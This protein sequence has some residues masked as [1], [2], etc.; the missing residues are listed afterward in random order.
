MA[1]AGYNKLLQKLQERTAEAVELRREL[2]ARDAE[3]ATLQAVAHTPEVAGEGRASR[4]RWAELEKDAVI[5]LSGV[6]IS[7]LISVVLQMFGVDDPVI[8][9]LSLTA[10]ALWL[11][12]LFVHFSVRYLQGWPHRLAAMVIPSVLVTIAFVQIDHWFM[13][14]RQERGHMPS[15]RDFIAAFKS[16]FPWLAQPPPPSVLTALSDSQFNEIRQIDALIG[17]KDEMELRNTFDFPNMLKF[18]LLLIRRSADTDSV[19]PSESKEMDAYWAGG[20]GIVDS[21]YLRISRHGDGPIEA[22]M[23]P[24]KIG[25]IN[26]S[27]RYIDAEKQLRELCD[28][29]D[30]PVDIVAALKDFNKTVASDTS[31]LLTSLNESYSAAPKSVLE[32]SDTSS[33]W[34]GYASDHYWQQFV[35]LGPKADKVRLAI[36][37]YLKVQ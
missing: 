30:L 22:T 32:D 18:N 7:I 23:V 21:R 24:G 20:Q 34:F 31:T 10:I 37:R 35:P 6:V 13:R 15:A 25:I 5:G 4:A 8:G 2:V 16:E 9:H 12:L 17:R 27:V 29:P 33:P 3:I 11:I 36:R 26:T 19:S 28:S 14:K 1:K